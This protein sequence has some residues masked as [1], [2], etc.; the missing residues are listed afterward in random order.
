MSAYSCDRGTGCS[1]GPQHTEDVLADIGEDQIGRDRCGLVEAGLAPFAPDVIFA[2]EG[3][4]VIGLHRRL[5][6][7]IEAHMR[8]SYA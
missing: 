2:G 6:G 3:E 7:R 4:A 1:I 5:G 8:L